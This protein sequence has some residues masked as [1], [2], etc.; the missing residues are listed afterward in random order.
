MDALCMYVLHLSLPT[1]MPNLPRSESELS[2][3]SGAPLSSTLSVDSKCPCGHTDFSHV[4]NPPSDCLANRHTDA[5][6]F[7]EL[8]L[9]S[10][11]DK[12]KA[13]AQ[14][15][16]EFVEQTKRIKQEF[17]R[18][19]TAVHHYTKSLNGVERILQQHIL[20]K[21]Q[22]VETSDIDELYKTFIE[23]ADFINYDIL[24]HKLNIL[25]SSDTVNNNVLRRLA[26]E[27]AKRYEA[28]F[29]EYAQQRV[30][31]LS[32]ILQDP[33]KRTHSVKKM[34]TIKVEEDFRSTAINR[35][36]HYKEAIKTVL[37][38]PP[39]VDLRIMSVQEG[40]VEICFEVIGSFVNNSI[41][42]TL[43]H[44][45]LNHDQKQELLSKNNIIL[46]TI[47]E[48]V[49]YCCCEILSDKVFA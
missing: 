20:L 27:A 45:Y 22:V 34:L 7:P 40:C 11:K 15:I 46:V 5:K 3:D 2:L 14:L 23:G 32:T 16:F 4:L 8:D 12:K 31:L 26:K 43:N 21:G 9:K 30:F 39:H 47:D 25:I 35:L 29:K 10:S 44:G 28:F 48:Q 41:C 18:F 37:E 1:E 6:N 24:L 13:Q 19:G 38:I 49:L 36:L 33:N 17:V 42:P